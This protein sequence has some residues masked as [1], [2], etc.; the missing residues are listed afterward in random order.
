M[1][2]HPRS[3]SRWGGPRAALLAVLAGAAALRLVG[4]QYGLPYPL[5]NPDEQTIVPRAW[6][7]V[8]GGGLDPDPF[9]D[10]PTLVMYLLAPFQAWQG[11]PSYLAAR[12]VV[13]ALGVAAVAASWWLGQRAYGSPVGG[14]VAA[15]AVAV[16][17]THVAYSRMAVTDIPLTLGVAA[18][19]ALMV[20]GRLEWAGPVA[21]LTAAAKY[22][23]VFLLVPLI[24]AGWH[25]RRRLVIALALAA[26]AFFAANPY[27]LVHPGEAG[28]DA[29]RAQR[30]AREE[31]LGFE[32]DHPAPIA[33][34]DRLWEGLGPALLVAGLG[35]ALAL[36]SRRR[37]DLVLASFVLAYFAALL[38]LDAHFERYVLPLVPALGALA[39]RLRWLAPVTALLLVVPLVWSIRDAH[40][41]TR[42]DTRV[43]ARAWIQ[44]HLP[45][46]AALAAESSSPPF[47]GFRVVRL[48]LPG[49]QRP[50][51]PDRD[52]ARL[53][54]AG[55][56][57]V[58]VT[59]A[60][61]D[62]V[63]A[64]RERYRS[65]V[66]FY[67]ELRAE[68]RRLYYLAPGGELAGPWVAVYRL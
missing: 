30:L 20:R 60:V 37:A 39:G 2:R 45:A 46:G 61:A 48:A 63:L 6:G 44:E 35:L 7:M 54:A 51:D 12:L 47:E 64:A 4:V 50:S 49:P 67:E 10:H 11:E 29:L 9:F 3:E 13:V 66:R 34:L 36:A 58:L 19:L 59:G 62:P 55:V 52:V 65:E 15:S 1:A 18:S 5:L 32:H 23:G 8:H 22:P 27:M 26:V 68:A 43:V 42:T 14:F 28:A 21:G 40:R 56:R 53:R 16:E 31:W 33:F 38:A 25:E 24:A 41:L 57:Y 17:T